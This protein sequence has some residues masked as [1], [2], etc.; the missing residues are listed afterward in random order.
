MRAAGATQLTTQQFG[1]ALLCAI[2]L[3]IAWQAVKWIA[4]RRTSAARD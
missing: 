4:R 2:A 1:L 3:L